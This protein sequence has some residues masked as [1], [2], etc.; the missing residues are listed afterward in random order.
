MCLRKNMFFLNITMK[1]R[2]SLS[3]DRPFQIFHSPGYKD[4]SRNEHTAQTEPS[5]FS[6]LELWFILG[7]RIFLLWSVIGMNLD[8]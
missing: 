5:E 1:K 7:K 2:K 6:H 4:Y 3:Q 8:L